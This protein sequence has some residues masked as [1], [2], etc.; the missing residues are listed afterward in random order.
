MDQ[1]IDKYKPSKLDQ[2]LFG[3]Y[4]SKQ[5]IIGWFNQRKQNL[6]SPILLITG[7]TGTGKTLIVDL[8]IAYSKAVTIKT[9]A[10]DERTNILMNRQLD[11]LIYRPRLCLSSEQE[12]KIFLLDEVDNSTDGQLINWLLGAA[13]KHGHVCSFIIIS[14][15]PGSKHIRTLLQKTSTGGKRV[16]KTT[17]IKLTHIK[18]TYPSRDALFQKLKSIA[19]E[20]CITHKLNESDIYHIV[21]SS[22]G[23]VRR[24]VCDLQWNSSMKKIPTLIVDSEEKPSFIQLMANENIFGFIQQ[25]RSYLHNLDI[26]ESKTNIVSVMAEYDKFRLPLF[27]ACNANSLIT[28][29]NVKS[30][31]SA[32]DRKQEKSRFSVRK[33]AEDKKSIMISEL[34][35]LAI[36]S[37]FCDATT[38]FDLLDSDIQRNHGDNWELQDYAMIEGFGRH[39]VVL[40]GGKKIG[41]DPMLV[42]PN[43]HYFATNIQPTENTVDEQWRIDQIIPIQKGAWRTDHFPLLRSLMACYL[44]NVYEGKESKQKMENIRDIVKSIRL[45]PERFAH[46]QTTFLQLSDIEI[47]DVCIHVPSSLGMSSPALKKVFDDILQ[48]YKCSATGK[49]D[50]KPTKSAIATLDDDVQ[51]TKRK[52][53]A[54]NVKVREKNTTKQCL[55]DE[56][57]FVKSPKNQISPVTPSTIT[58]PS[59]S[60]T[61]TKPSRFIST[62][63]KPKLNN[64]NNIDPN[65]EQRFQRANNVKLKKVTGKRK[66]VDEPKLQSPNKRSKMSLPSSQSR[67]SSFFVR[68]DVQSDQKTSSQKI[69]AKGSLQNLVQRFDD[70]DRVVIHHK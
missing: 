15:D 28:S 43:A 32:D 63:R 17:M 19:I 70:L 40:S 50:T 53:I 2:V 26:N 24:A 23:D 37:D 55:M 61:Q 27:M 33:S 58:E 35:Q 44:M 22:N 1:W 7:G 30:W 4:V 67:I 57:P 29:E 14:N 3:D 51:I 47:K 48:E 65:E 66:I 21:D 34:K 68:S 38:R 6:G 42:Y 16:T 49:I 41:R 13:E 64:N 60:P 54:S 62:K 45:L 31:Y 8:M 46:L 11:N 20:E 56:E 36:C 59:T 25:A 10:S 12:F 69:V 39:M 52:P 18:M 5:G 9:F